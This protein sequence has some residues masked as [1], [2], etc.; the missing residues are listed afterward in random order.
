MGV[1]MIQTKEYLTLVQTIQ[2][3]MWH[4]AWHILRNAADCSDAIQE[5]VLKGWQYRERLRDAEK[6]KAWQM[7]I[8]INECRNLQ[9]R[10]AKGRSAWARVHPKGESAFPHDAV[11]MREIMGLLP[12]NARALLCLYYFEGYSLQEIGRL[13]GISE[14]LAKSRLYR[15]RQQFKQLCGA[16]FR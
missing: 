1:R 9:R 15:A 6:F 11:E 7:R 10:Q 13:Q 3:L 12:E 16:D 5:A 4:T 8:L 2:N 14:A